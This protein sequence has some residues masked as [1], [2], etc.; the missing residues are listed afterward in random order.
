LDLQAGLFKRARA[1]DFIGGQAELFFDGKLGG[2]AAAGFGFAE[3][4]RDE[5]HEL[6]LRRAPGDYQTIQIFMDAGLD[7]QRSFDKSRVAH[8][9]SLPFVELMENDL[10]DAGM[11]YGVEAVES[12]AILKD[13][14]AEL[15]AVDAAIGSQHGLAEFLSDLGVGWLTGLDELVGEGVGVEDGESQIA[16]HSSD[17]AFAAGNSTGKAKAEHFFLIIAP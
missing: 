4:S 11:D 2:D 9:T 15:C 13:D 17:G 1:I 3:A 7:E 12:G 14:G 5:A 10:G 8:A 16:Q 6:L